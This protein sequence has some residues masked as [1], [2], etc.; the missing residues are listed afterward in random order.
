MNKRGSSIT[1][2]PVKGNRNQCGICRST[3]IQ[4]IAV[5]SKSMWSLGLEKPSQLW[6]QAHGVELHH[7]NTPGA[8]EQGCRVHQ[9][10]QSRKSHPDPTEG[11]SSLTLQRHPLDISDI[12]G[13]IGAEHQDGEE[14]HGARWALN[15]N[16]GRNIFLALCKASDSQ[17]KCLAFPQSSDKRELVGTKIHQID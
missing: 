7:G 10:H 12:A 5:F 2:H 8:H 15:F 4:R 11:S 14:V 3:A 6:Q 16:L 17:I 1:C 9:C 13:G